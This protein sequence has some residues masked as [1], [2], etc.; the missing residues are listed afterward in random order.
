MWNVLRNNDE[1]KKPQVKSFFRSRD[2][3]QS[4][5]FLALK[6]RIF[7]IIGF[8]RPYSVYNFTINMLKWTTCNLTAEWNKKLKI[9]IRT[10]LWLTNSMLMFVLQKS[11][12]FDPILDVI[13]GQSKKGTKFIIR[14]QNGL[15]ML[16]LS[17]GHTFG[18]QIRLKSHPW[19]SFFCLF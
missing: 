19:L 16:N 15:N 3:A 8:K 7:N 10:D 14:Q 1:Q 6:M 4:Y 13:G 9:G 2:I 5:A 17:P 11:N 12:F 18:G